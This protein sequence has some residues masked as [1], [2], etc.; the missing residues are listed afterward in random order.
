[1]NV[2]SAI[3]R[4]MRRRPARHV[5]VVPLLLFGLIGTGA[6]WL[7]GYLLWPTWRA[8]PDVAPSR[9]PISVGGTLFN[10]PSDALRMKVQKRSGPQDRI[11]LA[12]AYPSLD[13]SPSAR[14]VSADTVEAAPPELD[15]MILSIAERGD[16][17]TPAERVQAIYPRYLQ[18]DPQLR[19]GLTMRAF[20]DASPYRGEDLFTAGAFA[21]RCTRDAMIPGMCLTERRIDGADLTFRFPRAWLADWRGVADAMSRLTAELHGR[22][23]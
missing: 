10:V 22:A 5:H 11:D 12:F 1:M 15:R 6:V 21:A 8:A 19:D 4:P 9:L 23:R 20:S 2:T 18:G 17:L 7:I 3:D 13:P 14:H 16:G